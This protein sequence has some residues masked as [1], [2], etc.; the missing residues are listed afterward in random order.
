[1]Q[2]APKGGY[3]T[4]LKNKLSEEGE[5]IDKSDENKDDDFDDDFD[6]EF[7]DDEEDED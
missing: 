4:L 6:D 2:E 5:I 3:F 7:E 1:M